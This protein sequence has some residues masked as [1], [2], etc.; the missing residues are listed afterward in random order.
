LAEEKVEPLTAEQSLRKDETS[1]SEG[2]G[3]LIGLQK[4]AKSSSWDSP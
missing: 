1:C 2:C 4:F 3:A